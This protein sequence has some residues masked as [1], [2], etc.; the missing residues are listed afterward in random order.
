MENKSTNSLTLPKELEALTAEQLS[1]NTAENIT[2]PTESEYK[3]WIYEL[4]EYQK[5]MY[6]CFNEYLRSYEYDYKV[7]DYYERACEAISNLTK[8]QN[9]IQE[10]TFSRGGSKK[11]LQKN[12][13]EFYQVGDKVVD[14]G[15]VSVSDL[16]ES[17]PEF[18]GGC[19]YKIT[20]P[21]GFPIIDVGRSIKE[22]LLC[23]GEAEFLLPAGTEFLIE[24]IT[25]LETTS[26][27]IKMRALR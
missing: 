10:I 17:S 14:Y 18:R 8:L 16:P 27:K 5:T 7:N 9:T 1:M 23:P 11:F 13:R 15:F 22:N 12:R 19:Q 6:E 2:I 20:V 26:S 25:G 4:R 3:Q 24:E 21:K